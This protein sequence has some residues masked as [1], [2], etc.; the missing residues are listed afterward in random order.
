MTTRLNP[1]YG[2]E[3]TPARLAP[4]IKA[5]TVIDPGEI[6]VVDSTGHAIAATAATGLI[7]MGKYEGLEPLDNSAGANAAFRVPVRPG[8]YM[9]DNSAAADEVLVTDIGKDCFF[10]TSGQVAKT[11][12]GGTRSAAGKVLDVKD[13]KVAVS[14]GPR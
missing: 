12:G 2:T 13:G 8:P 5:A 7:P 9:L 4:P 3:T 11:D 6:V 10:V 14:I 1:Q